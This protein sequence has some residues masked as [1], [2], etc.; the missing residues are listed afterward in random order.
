MS[1]QNSIRVNIHEERKLD[2][3][4]ELFLFRTSMFN[5]VNSIFPFGSRNSEIQAVLERINTINL[6]EGFF[7]G[8]GQPPRSTLSEDI[9]FDIAVR[10]SLNHYKT[11]EKK[12][13]IKLDI[14]GTTVDS[15]M[16]DEICTICVSEYEV[17]DQITKTKCN[18]VFHTNCISEW[19]KYKTECPV[20]RKSIQTIDESIKDSKEYN[21]SSQ[22][23]LNYPRLAAYDDEDEDNMDEGDDE[24]D[25]EDEH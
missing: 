24:E 6:M 23:P 21:T 17:G 9:M 12:P 10:E 18:H 4:D 13:N 11:Q 22:L 15:E 19:V 7:D 14:K 25:E 20:C 2:A 8:F 3:F 16:K 1:N 5:N